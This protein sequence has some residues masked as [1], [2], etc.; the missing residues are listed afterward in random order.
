MRLPA[1]ACLLIL[2]VSAPAV[3]QLAPAAP[4]APAADPTEKPEYKQAVEQALEEYRL[5]HFEEARS[6]FERAHGIDANARTLRGLGMVEF[7]L[8]HYVRAAEL[9][10][11]S[12][13]STK[14]PLTAEQ[15]KSVEQLLSRTRQ[16]IAEYAVKVEPPRPDIAVEL[17]GKPIELSDEGK[18]SIEAGEHT[19]RISGGPEL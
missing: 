19:L 14:K 11:E 3:A 9:L 15:R 7:E 2:A 13:E 8:R 10:E 17:D 4:P 6:L 1:L 12:L 18:I 16:F 5:G